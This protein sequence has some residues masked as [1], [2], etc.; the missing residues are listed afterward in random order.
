MLFKNFFKALFPLGYSCLCCGHEIFEEDAFVCSECLP[1][2]PFLKGRQ[3]E[4]CGEPISIDKFCDRCA[5]TNFP[6]KK[7]IS[8]FAY[9]GIVA[10]AIRKLKYSN[11][12]NFA[13]FLSAYMAKVFLSH[14]IKCDF[15]IAVPLCSVRLKQRGYNQAEVLA[16]AFCKRAKIKLENNVLARTKTTPSQTSLDFAER[17]ANMKDSFEVVNKDLVANKTILIIDDVFTTGA[18]ITECANALKSAGAKEVFAITA[19][20]T[21]LKFAK[22]V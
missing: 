2:L 4:K 21:V 18:T 11:R 9:S 10:Y 8:P 19:G 3:C 6:F 17:L 12:K 22:S 15:A 7:V 5:S 20:H 16:K 13:E 14:A 1:T